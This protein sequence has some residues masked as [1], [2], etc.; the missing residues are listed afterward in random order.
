MLNADSRLS[1]FLTQ[2]NHYKGQRA[3]YKAFMPPPDLELSTYHT[4][5]LDADAIRD[6]AQTNVLPDIAIGRSIYGHADLPV[7]SYAAQNLTATRDDDP[8]R[9]T[10]IAGWPVGTADD[11][12]THK[13]IALELAELALLR[14]FNEPLTR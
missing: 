10:L 4:D 12:E 8:E 6:L 9:H 13:E 3:T 14:L 2:S 5:D 7:A 1:R 11:K